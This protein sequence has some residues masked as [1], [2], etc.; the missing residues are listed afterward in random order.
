MNTSSDHP[1]GDGDK[2]KLTA[3]TFAE[4][5]SMN[6]VSLLAGFGVGWLV[7]SYL[8]TIPIFMFIGLLAGAGCGVYATYRRIRRYL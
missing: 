2:P 8:G 6:A 5:G 4:L 1:A 3:F 7:D